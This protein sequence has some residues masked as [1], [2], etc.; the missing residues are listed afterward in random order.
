MMF[1]KLF[2]VFFLYALFDSV[3]KTEGGLITDLRKLRGYAN[4]MSNEA[5]KKSD[6][7]FQQFQHSKSMVKQDD[8]RKTAKQL[9]IFELKTTTTTTIS[10]TVTKKKLKLWKKDWFGSKENKQK[11]LIQLVGQDNRQFELRAATTEKMSTG[12]MKGMANDDVQPTGVTQC[13]LSSSCRTKG[14]VVI[15]TKVG[16]Q[17]ID[18]NLPTKR[19][20]PF[21]PQTRTAGWQSTTGGTKCPTKKWKCYGIIEDELATDKLATI[22]T[23]WQVYTLPTCISKAPTP[24]NPITKGFLRM[25]STDRWRRRP[26]DKCT[27]I[28][29][30]YYVP[31]ESLSNGL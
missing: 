26:A 16:D 4:I 10:T 2:W 6:I 13:L 31:R 24:I 14:S 1:Q 20:E 9:K 27:S 12:D 28:P 8:S 21:T 25:T 7:T 15:M 23:L 11:S 22:G 19:L 29:V 18:P 30:K 17:T 5:G 3:I